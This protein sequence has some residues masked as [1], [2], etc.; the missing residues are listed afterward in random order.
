MLATVNGVLVQMVMA[1]RV[2]F[3]LSRQG[4]LPAWL[5]AVNATT[6][7]PLTATVLVVAAILALALFYPIATLAGTTS[8]ITLTVFALCN[9]ALWRLKKMRPPPEGAINLPFWLPIL[10]AL[11][12]GTVLAL[13]LIRRFAG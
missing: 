10:G 2:L 3:G 7:T 4:G 8:L 9:L 13:E 12:S 11:V 6:R 1:S 5:G